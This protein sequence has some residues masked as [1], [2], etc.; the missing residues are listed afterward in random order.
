MGTKH[1]ICVSA[2]ILLVGYGAAAEGAYLYPWSPAPTVTSPVNP[3]L[4]GARDIVAAWYAT[5]GAYHYFRIDLREAPVTGAQT[6]AEIY[7]I[8]IDAISGGGDNRDISYIPQGLS[9][10]DH[11]LDSHFN[12]SQGYLYFH[13][14]H[15]S[16]YVGWYAPAPLAADQH[17]QSENGGRTLEWK[18][19][20]NA[21]NGIG[22]TFTWW[23]SDIIQGSPS[24]TFDLTSP[25]YVPE[26]GT[27]V[28]LSLALPIVRGT[29][30]RSPV[31][32]GKG[33]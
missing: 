24:T 12:E 28:L 32:R 2:G 9:G 26:P 8:Y 29:R 20:I 31:P 17:Q 7:G 30:K 13:D 16:P 15:W 4:L 22:T 25:Q 27:L 3:A 10:I 5:D 14:H 19:E 11:I 18:T 33:S 1:F 6:A 21:P 23:A